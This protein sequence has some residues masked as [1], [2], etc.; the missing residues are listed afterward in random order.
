MAK[1]RPYFDRRH[2]WQEHLIAI[3]TLLNLGLVFFD[4]TYLYTRDFYLQTIPSLTQLYDPIKGIRPHPETESYLGRVDA[5]EAQV[6]ATGLQSSQV[7]GLLA[8]QRLLSQKLI[9]GNPFAGA[10]KSGT[11]ETIK[12]EIR[13]RTGQNFASDAFAT[14]W[15]QPYLAQAGWQQEIEFW[16][17]QIRPFIQT[18]YYRGV[19]RFGTGIDY[20]WLLDLPFILIFALDIGANTSAIKHRYPHLT[21]LEA[22]LRRWYDLFLLLPFWRWLR[23]IPASFRLYNVQLLNLE[24]VQAQAHR[25]FVIG[26]AVDLM[27]MVGIY[28]IDQMQAS[29][30][31][32]DAIHWLLHPE[33]R[34]PYVQVNTRDEVTEIAARIVNVSVYDVLPQLQ[35]DIEDLLHHSINNTLKQ[36]PV[37]QQL[38]HFPGLHSLPAQLTEN[39]AKSLSQITYNSLTNT[40]EDPAVAEITNRLSRNFRDVLEAELHKKHNF[41]EIQTLLVDML[42]EIKLNYV[43]GLAEVGIE[44]IVEQAEQLH[45]RVSTHAGNPA[46]PLTEEGQITHSPK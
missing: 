17:T 7:E 31:R 44:Q 6:V 1:S 4:L 37:Y 19:G 33:S 40:V 8:Q 5:L 11:L 10:N 38:Q 3:L 43:K 16:N 30:K 25:D 21:W 15:S 9:E 35:P 13:G 22:I 2:P 32:G 18:N 12:Q 27:E 41:Q 23:V 42:E 36:F 28:T 24:P 20:F 34:Q 46:H 14:F 45:R 29:V 26:F 39:L